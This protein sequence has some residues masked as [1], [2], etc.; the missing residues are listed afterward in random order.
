MSNVTDEICRLVRGRVRSQ[1]QERVREPA[2]KRIMRQTACHACWRS[3]SDVQLALQIR[4]EGPVRH[5]VVDTFKGRS[6]PS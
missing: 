4:V 5:P 3:L 2:D 1:V 6:D